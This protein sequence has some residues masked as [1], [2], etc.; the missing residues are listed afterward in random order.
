M[1]QASIIT[2]SKK[3]A[4]EKIKMETNLKQ[5]QAIEIKSLISHPKIV[6]DSRLL[7][8]ASQNSTLKDSQEK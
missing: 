8:S 7:Q 3:S 6:A 1:F 2:N 5:E 4:E